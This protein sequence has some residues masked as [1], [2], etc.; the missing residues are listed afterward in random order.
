MLVAPDYFRRWIVLACPPLLLTLRLEAPHPD[1]LHHGAASS[2]LLRCV[3]ILSS[4]DGSPHRRHHVVS[5]AVAVCDDTMPIAI[6]IWILVSP[7]P[8]LNCGIEQPI[9]VGGFGICLTSLLHCSL[10]CVLAQ[11]PRAI[12]CLIL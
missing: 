8:L 3:R 5:R 11:D 9:A 4:R 10:E 7:L 12:G 1:G 6:S 2:A